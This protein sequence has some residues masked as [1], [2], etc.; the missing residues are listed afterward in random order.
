MNPTN[1]L[2][3]GVAIY[4]ALAV[5][6]SVWIGIFVY[7]WRIDAHARNLRRELDRQQRREQEQSATPNVSI[8]RVHTPE[9][10]TVDS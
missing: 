1:L 10:E 3:A 2:E 7:L 6:L 4:V 5:A 8:T 9:R